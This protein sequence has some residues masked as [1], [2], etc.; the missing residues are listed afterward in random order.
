MDYFEVVIQLLQ[1]V[2][3]TQREAIE[4]A[5]LV[6]ADAIQTDHLVYAFGATHA[7]ILAQELFYRAG[8]LVPVNP[9]LPPGL[10]TDV[11]PSTL[12]SRLERM[13]GFG[14]QILAELPIE[15]GDVL[16]AHS[17]SGR[18]AAV[19]EIAQGARERGAF[20]IALTS[21]EY[22]RA[23][24]PRQPG[25]PRLF[26][27]ADLVLDNRA[28]VG[29]AAIALPGLPQKVG[30][31]STVIGAA[32]LNTIVVRVAE[33]LLQRTGDPPVFMS[34]NLDGG[35]EHNKRWLEHYG[36]RLTYL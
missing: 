10:T 35:D 20:V 21:L 17:V 1:E 33:L 25:M 14:A 30:P 36:N 18:N 12:T 24:Q 2:R 27:A 13:P 19:V 7:G 34:A 26:E 4:R 22:S 31:T 9:I 23:V 3:E 6:I 8:G 28:T 29:D 11:R 15:A 5:A 32:I 16:I